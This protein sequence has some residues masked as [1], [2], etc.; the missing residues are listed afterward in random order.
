MLVEWEQVFSRQYD[1][2]VSIDGI[3]W[4]IERSI[5]NGNGGQ[6]IFNQLDVFARYI[7]ISSRLCD[8]NYGVSI[9]EITIFGKGR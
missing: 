1:I 4:T 7:R 5:L 8:R 3:N 9:Y 2:G 6:V